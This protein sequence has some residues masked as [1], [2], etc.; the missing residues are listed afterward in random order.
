MEPMGRHQSLSWDLKLPRLPGSGEPFR[1]VYCEKTACGQA[2]NRGVM[3]QSTWEF[4]KIGDPNIV[5]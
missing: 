3:N 4:P 1:S 2:V 5:P